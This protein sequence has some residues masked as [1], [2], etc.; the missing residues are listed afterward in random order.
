MKAAADGLI[1]D[2]VTSPLGGVCRQVGGVLY[3]PILVQH[4]W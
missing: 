1:V 3:G 4:L 2:P